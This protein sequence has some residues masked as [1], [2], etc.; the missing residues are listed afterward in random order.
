M[1]ESPGSG[2]GFIESGDLSYP[3]IMAGLRSDFW[4]EIIC[5]KSV[6][7]TNERALVLPLKFP[8]AGAAIIADSQTK[9]RGRLGRVWVSPPGRNIYM[10]ALLAPEIALRD[11]ALLTVAATLACVWALRNKT[12]LDVKVKWPNDLMADGKK[13]GGILTELRSVN[14]RIK[15]AAI[16]I[17]IN[18]NTRTGDFPAALR[19]SATSVMAETGKCHSRSGVVSE[20]LNE[21]ERWYRKLIYA[22]GFPLLE[23]WRKLSSTIGKGVRVTLY[24]D[25]LSGLAEDIDENGMLVLKL[26]SG[27][28]RRISAGDLTELR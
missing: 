25:V 2:E 21:L 23:E 20:V 19:S 27:E 15:C 16:G 26:P 8:G 9:G 14:D 3:E 24:A 18:I 11:A 12:G 10:S 6:D 28:R 1:S 17:G 7:S 5:Y 13:V 22:G 4:K